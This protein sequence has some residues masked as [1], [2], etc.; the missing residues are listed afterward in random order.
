MRRSVRNGARAAALLP[1]AYALV[2][3]PWQ[4]RWGTTAAEAAERLPGDD[5]VPGA[6]WTATRAVTIDAT[7]GQVWPWL[8]QMGAGERAGWYS[9]DRVDNAGV[10]SA[11]RI[12]PELQALAVGDSLPFTAGATAAFT[13]ASLEPCRSLVLAN[14]EPAG[15]VTAALVLRAV[16]EDRCRLLH[17]VRF[18]VRPRPAAVAWA[19]VMDVGD[20]VMARRMLLGVKARAERRARRTRG[21]AEPRDDSADGPL[22]FDLSVDV[23]H[24][25]SAVF[26][27]L[28]DVQD[29]VD[30][31]PRGAGVRMTKEPAGPTCL[32]TRW[33]ERV[34]VAPGVW[35]R[36]DSVVTD[37]EQP[38]RL[39]LA[40]RSPWFVGE[41]S[42]SLAGVDGGTRLRQQETLRLRWPLGPL[43]RRVDAALRPRLLDRLAD[44]RDAVD[45]RGP[46]LSERYQA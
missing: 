38:A 43:A 25:P 30:E 3:R 24:P 16:G 9:Y 36:V 23:R 11:D 7:P 44:L 29:H 26:A 5:L 21:G 34:R 13:V 17:R 1:V 20:F 33:R 40:F 45:R 28:A 4:L 19:L 32:G 2:Y 10:P 12:R 46:D 8:V 22:R 41:L 6:E 18:R 14:N 15:T 31:A 42:Y 35:M 39:R 27:L 37:I